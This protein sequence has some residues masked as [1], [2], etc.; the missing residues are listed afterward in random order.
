MATETNKTNVRRAFEEGLNQGKVA[1]FDELCAPS[2]SYHEPVRPD[3]RTLGDYKRYI[4]EVHRA[5]PDIHATIE[6]LIAEGEQVVVRYS[7]RG[8]N[9]GE[10]VMP[11]MH[12]PATGKPVTVLGILIVRTVEGKAVEAWNQMDGLGLFQQLGL[13]P[14]PQ[15][16]G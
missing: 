13:I 7:W 4:T 9:T 6:D 10:L 8:T 3:V 2:Y 1:V 12:L 15:P 14:I 11:T 16:V 5:F